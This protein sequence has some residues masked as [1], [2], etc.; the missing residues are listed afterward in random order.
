MASAPE[1]LPQALL[2][3][4]EL[5]DPDVLDPRLQHL[6]A[7]HLPHD[8]DDGVHNMQV[9]PQCA[10]AVDVLCNA[11]VVSVADG[12]PLLCRAHL[13]DL[14]HGRH[15]AKH[16]LKRRQCDHALQD[17]NLQPG[18]AKLGVGLDERLQ[19]HGQVPPE[20]AK[21]ATIEPPPQFVPKTTRTHRAPIKHPAM[22]AAIPLTPEVGVVN[23]H[24]GVSKGSV[25]RIAVLPVRNLRA[26]GRDRRQGP[27]ELAL[28]GVLVDVVGEEDSPRIRV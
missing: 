6:V 24:V 3:H 26:V 10:L 20:R 17:T 4:A 13:H 8:P 22:Q 12:W 11:R 15:Q 9:E 14:R 25:V 23:V 21:V 5:A 16:L 2:L 18:T 7:R 1:D 28:E 27:R 19:V